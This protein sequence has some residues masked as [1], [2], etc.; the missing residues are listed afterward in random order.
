MFLKFRLNNRFSHSRLVSSYFV[1][2]P[3]PKKDKCTQN[4]STC[5]RYAYYLWLLNSLVEVEYK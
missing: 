1:F 4:K 5:M 2:A 3:P